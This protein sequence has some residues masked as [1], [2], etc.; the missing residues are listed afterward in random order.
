[1]PIV[2]PIIAAGKSYEACH[3]GGDTLRARIRWNVRMFSRVD[4]DDL[5]GNFG[6]PRESELRERLA[7]GQLAELAPPDFPQQD[8]R[9]VGDA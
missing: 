2:M 8:D 1:M 7:L 3:S 5:A 4:P 6:E 9:R